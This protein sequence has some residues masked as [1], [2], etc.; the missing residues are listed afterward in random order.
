MLNFMRKNRGSIS[1]FLCLIL[2]P[3]VTYSAMIVDASR[4]QSC[5]TQLQGAGDLTMN[6]ALSEYEQILEDM[7]GL[8]AV[9]ENSDELKKSLEN[10]FYETISGQLNSTQGDTEYTKKLAQER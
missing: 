8:F 2:L 3:M 6:A 10:Y 7:Y 4:M 5:R 9:S 1:I